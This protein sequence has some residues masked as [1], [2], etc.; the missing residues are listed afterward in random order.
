MG[1]RH[2]LDNSRL[3]PLLQV[4]WNLARLIWAKFTGH[5]ERA[6]D[7][8]L[9]NQRTMNSLKEDMDDTEFECM[10]KQ[11]RKFKNK[12]KIDIYLN[13]FG[14]EDEMYCDHVTNE[15]QRYTYES[16]CSNSTCPAKKKKSS[17]SMLTFM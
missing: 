12:L 13:Y 16:I 5:V 2:P 7:T 11:A 14:F 15:L 4:D 10:N 1:F 17:R 3:S 9:Y 8:Q 6:V